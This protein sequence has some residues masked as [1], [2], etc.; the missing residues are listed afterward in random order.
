[1]GEPN[2]TTEKNAK[3]P[4]AS[5]RENGE[6]AGETSLAVVVAAAVV[7]IVIVEAVVVGAPVAATVE[8]LNVHVA[9][10]GRPEHE[11][12]MVPLNP[13]EDKTASEVVPADP[14]AVTVTYA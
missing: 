2:I 5:Q 11:S 8:G 1:V 4:I 3:I 10:T 7:V 12:V 14:G 13:V 6:R 9:P